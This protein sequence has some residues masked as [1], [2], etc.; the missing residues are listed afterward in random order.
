M[1]RL[2]K[3][4]F[5]PTGG[6]QKV[7]DYIA[8][9]FEG[10]CID[11]SLLKQEEMTFEKEDFVIFAIPSFSGR[12]PKTASER[13]GA[14]NGNGAKCA[15]VVVYGNRAYEDTLLELKNVVKE[16][17]F[18]PVAGAAVLAEHSIARK[19]AAGRPD[20]DD[21]EELKSFG[22]QIF[23]QLDRLKEVEVPGNEP[24]RAYG[25]AAMEP[26]PTKQCNG[27][28]IC[29][30]ECPVQAIDSD[31]RA[32]PEVC[33]SCMRCVSICPGQNRKAKEEM[34]NMICE[35]LSVFEE[36]RKANEF[37]LVF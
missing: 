25:A 11:Y 15:I 31:Y 29:I 3:I 26:Q 4:T 16:S 18:V 34:Q 20:A 2:V 28:G 8:E 6:T 1:N 9:G 30:T 19:V 21:R 10:S 5:S 13:I 32:N 37:F 24:Y 7:T 17:N 12:V 27:C 36:V 33:I 23:D 35:K 22:K 14:L